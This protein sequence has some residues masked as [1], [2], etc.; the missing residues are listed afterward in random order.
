MDTRLAAIIETFNA[1]LAALGFEA[2]RPRHWVRS[3]K[4]PIREIFELQPL[5]GATYSA[6]WGFGLD[7]VPRYGRGG[8]RWKRTTKS[9]QCDLRIDPIDETG[10]VPNWCSIALLWGAKVYA[11]EIARLA[12]S[13][14]AAATLDFDRVSSCVELLALFEKRSQLH[15]RRFSLENYVQ[16][17]LAWGLLLHALG[18]AA[19]GDAHLARFCGRF[20]VARNHPMIARALEAAQSP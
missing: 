9:A 5:K 20:N 17:D 2:P 8:F 11:M 7:F 16:T 10:D 18:E 1:R 13:T 19:A 14:I 15:F 6:C 4:Q 3:T 12:T